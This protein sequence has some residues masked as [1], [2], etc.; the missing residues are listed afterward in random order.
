M[1]AKTKKVTTVLVLL[2]LAVVALG[3]VW[4]QFGPQP[5]AGEKSITI[6]AK[7][8][9]IGQSAFAGCTSLTDVVFTDGCRVTSIPTSA[10][11]GDNSLTSVNLPSTVTSIGNY[12]FRNTAITAVE[13]KNV[14][15][16]GTEAFL[17][18][19][20]LKSAAVSGKL[21]TVGARAFSG[22]S[23]LESINLTTGLKS[24]GEMAFADCTSLKAINLPSTLTTLSGN[25]FSGCS[26]VTSF[27]VDSGNKSFK[28]K[29][30]A[31]FDKTGF[32]LIY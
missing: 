13:L 8:K 19:S 27:T 17:G 3:I 9:T 30:G 16:I 11:D 21:L 31:L 10:F 24:I 4:L 28:Y 29:D 12:A 18:C 14:S 25:P 2:A 20:S 7:V 6:S 23:A 26:G 1:S 15:S 22:C 32:T 5:T